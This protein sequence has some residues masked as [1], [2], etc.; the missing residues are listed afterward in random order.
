MTDS[1]ILNSQQR[2][3]LQN[4]I[5][6]NDT[7]DCTEEIRAKK[8]SVLIRNDVKQMIYLKQKYLRLQKSNPQ[9]FDKICTGQ[10]QFLFNNYT[11]IY[12]KIKNDT[13]NLTIFDKFLTILKQ[14]EDG[15]LNQ[16]EGSYLVGKLLKEL[17]IDSAMRN[18]E[19]LDAKDRKKKVQK[20]PVQLEKK[21]SYK[22]FK[23]MHE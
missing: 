2:L 17:Y 12:N 4:L 20:K 18:Q 23:I 1:K 15:E 19:R 22:D 8:Q 11:D 7:D 3:D 16:H 9:E 10:C 13:L 6:A 14:I 21:I 5:K